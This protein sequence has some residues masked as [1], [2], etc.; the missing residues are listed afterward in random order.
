MCP[1]MPQNQ[2][3]VAVLPDLPPPP[4]LKARQV[5]ALE[6]I[7]SGTT[8][9]EAAR[10]AHVSRRTLERWRWRDPNFVA[11]FNLGQTDRWR[12]GQEALR[13]LLPKAIDAIQQ[14]LEQGPPTARLRAASLVLRTL[15]FGHTGERPLDPTMHRPP[16]SPDL[17]VKGWQ[18]A[19]ERAAQDKAWSEAVAQIAPIMPLR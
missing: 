11:A 19:Q 3:N 15:S 18:E 5:I 13:G 6:A 14:T 1:R 2:H 9:T 17:V 12:A 8:H 4:R 7:L 16:T 10:Q